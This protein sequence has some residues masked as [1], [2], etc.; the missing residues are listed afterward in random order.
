MAVETQNIKELTEEAS[1]ALT[2]LFYIGKD[3]GSGVFVDRSIKSSVFNP[4]TTKGDLLGHDATN[5]VRIPVGADGSILLAD[6]SN[7]NGVSWQKGI[8]PTASLISDGTFHIASGN[9]GSITAST[10]ANELVIEGAGNTGISI[11]CPDANTARI[12]FGNPTAGGNLDGQIAYSSNGSLKFFTNTLE[13]FNLGAGEATF[14]QDGLDY[15]FRIESDLNI[16]ML[17]VDAGNNSVHIDNNLLT[18]AGDGDLVMANGKFM[19]F[20]NSAGT[21]SANFGIRASTTDNLDLHVP[22]ISD[23]HQLLWNN[24]VR[25]IFA[26]ENGGGGLT[27]ANESSSDHG[28]PS[29]N[30]LVLYIKDDGGVTK[31]Y[32]RN[33]TGVK[34][35]ATV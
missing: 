25:L 9:A 33:T 28:V 31:L 35:I 12:L 30:R 16:H 7:G 32:Y 10:L 19:R 20:I 26:E 13:R 5:R 14:N 21:T 15:D 27:F 23:L 1:L 17:F 4:I 34:E 3:Q 11:L 18:G 22:V 6:S 8:A 24:Q 29:T 2:D